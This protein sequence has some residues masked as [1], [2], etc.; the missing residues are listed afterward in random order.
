MMKLELM[1]ASGKYG[2]N[3]VTVKCWSA[4]GLGSTVAA[5][6]GTHAPPHMNLHVGASHSLTSKNS[7]GRGDKITPQAVKEKSS[8]EKKKVQS[9]LG[10]FRP[11][12]R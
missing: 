10:L 11:N 9:G 3:T 2:A 5:K 7:G 12:G 4:L 1:R 8:K 6:S